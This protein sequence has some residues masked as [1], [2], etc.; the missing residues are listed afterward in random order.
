M[1][2]ILLLIVGII[3][4]LFLGLGLV[5]YVPTW[6][7]GA[8]SKAKLVKY[9]YSSGGGKAGEVYKET[10]TAYDDTHAIVSISKKDRHDGA[11]TENECLVDI[12]ILEDIQEVFKKYHMKRWDGKKFSN[13]FVADGPSHSY[14][15]NFDNGRYVHFSSQ[16]YPEPY[17]NKLSLI[18]KIV[19]SYE[20]VSTAGEQN[21]STEETDMGETDIL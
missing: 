19:K 8:W 15:F 7:A 3:A 13:T 11:E 12:K 5:I 17:A 20:A 6:K 9:R 10:I 2:K 4:V 14:R 21:V 1:L 18:T 16:L